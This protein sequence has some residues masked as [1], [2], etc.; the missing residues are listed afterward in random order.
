MR[1]SHGDLFLEK[2]GILL[3]GGLFGLLLWDWG[4]LVSRGLVLL[5]RIAFF[6]IAGIV[7]CF[8]YLVAKHFD[9]PWGVCLQWLMLFGPLAVVCGVLYVAMRYF[10]VTKKAFLKG[11][12]S[13]FIIIALSQFIKAGAEHFGLTWLWFSNKWVFSFLLVSVCG[14]AGIG[15]KSL[16]MAWFEF[17]EKDWRFPALSVLPFGL[18]HGRS[19]PTMWGV[20]VQAVAF[21]C[22]M[23][24][25]LLFAFAGA[26]HFGPPFGLGWGMVVLGMVLVVLLNLSADFLRKRVLDC[27]GKSALFLRGMWLFNWFLFTCIMSLIL[28]LASLG[29]KH[30]GFSWLWFQNKWVFV[31]IMGLLSPVIYGVVHEGIRC[32]GGLLGLFLK[33]LGVLL[34]DSR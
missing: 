12:A 7:L 17:L 24:V 5:K 28:A 1:V 6:C 29:A 4:L 19:V 14:C 13:S 3:H 11:I 2:I 25:I 22:M 8:A 15:L 10:R 16:V 23:G 33:R 18:A 27:E 30:L 32:V 21:C 9:V 31:C 34:V 26:K 20:V